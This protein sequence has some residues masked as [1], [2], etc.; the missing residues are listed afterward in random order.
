MNPKRLFI[1]KYLVTGLFYLTVFYAHA[2]CVSIDFTGPAT[3]CRESNFRI[4]NNTTNAGFEWDLCPY[5]LAAMPSAQKVMSTGLSSNLDLEIIN[6]GDQYYGFSPDYSANKLFRFDFGNDIEATP[7]V[8]DLGNVD[9]M[10]SL[11]NSIVLVKE[12]GTWLGILANAGDNKIVL[13]N[14][15]N[16]LSNTPSAT[17]LLQKGGA[18]FTKLAVANGAGANALIIAEYG[19]SRVTAV[20][21]SQGFLM[22]PDSNT[23][24]VVAG[25]TPIDI[26]VIQD[27]GNWTALLLSFDNRKLYHLDFGSSFASAPSITEY[28]LTFS[29]DAYRLSLAKEGVNYYGLVTNV[30][31]GLARLSFDD[32]LSNTPEIDPLGNF[33]FLSNSRSLFVKAY[34]GLWRGFMINF[35]DGDLYRLTF[36][37]NCGVTPAYSTNAT[38]GNIRFSFSGPQEISLKATSPDGRTSSMSQAIMVSDEI[39][40]SISIQN[41]NSCVGALVD[42]ALVTSGSINSQHWDFGDGNTSSAPDPSHIYNSVG[43]YTVIADVTFENACTNSHEITKT[44]FSAPQAAFSLP[45]ASPICTNDELLFL[46]N[47]VTDPGSTPNWRWF[48][49]GEEVSSQ[50]NLNHFFSDK[51]PHSVKLHVSIPGCEDEQTHAFGPLLEGPSVDFST[52]QKCLGETNIFTNTT[53]GDAISYVWDFDDGNTSTDTNPENLFSSAGIYSVSL[54]ATSSNGC[55]NNRTKQITIYSNPAVDFAVNPPPHVCSGSS[56]PFVN[57]TSNPIDGTI[58]SWLWQFGDSGEENESTLQDPSH[59]FVN[60]GIYNVKLTAT[61]AEGCFG[62]H[63]KA[64]EIF[65]SPS[66]SIE[67]GPACV[68]VPS[69][70]TALGNDIV[71]YY[72]EIGT[73]Y[74]EQKDP[75]HTFNAPGNYQLRLIVQGSNDCE[76]VV[77]QTISVPVPL[78]PD[79]SVTRNCVGHEA[80]FTDLTSGADPVTVHEWEFE[81]SVNASGSPASY[82]FSETGSHSVKLTVTTGSGCSYSSTKVIDVLV[83]PVAD[84][85][86][87]PEEGGSPLEV[88]FTNSSTGA[89][90][91]LWAFGNG[92]NSEEISPMFT[93]NDVGTFTT[94]LT[95]ANDVGCESSFSKSVNVLSPLPDVDV[96]SIHTIENADGTLGIVV[97]LHNKG[98]TYLKDLALDIDLSGKIMLREIVDAYIAPFSLYNVTLDYAVTQPSA[99]TFLCANALLEN[100]LAPEGNRMCTELKNEAVLFTPFPN[101]VRDELVLEWIS[102]GDQMIEFLLIDSFGKTVLNTQKNAKPGL[103]QTTCNVT[104][105][106]SGIYTLIYKSGSATSTQRILVVRD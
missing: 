73:L 78:V 54:T 79:F 91:Y 33:G 87:F 51:G 31:G 48:V 35:S 24:T 14:F 101:P 22:P 82:V 46:N 42:F 23:P 47:S 76:T 88:Q 71:Y 92:S 57:F 18:G 19:G 89:T 29:F 104:A 81:S 32:D 25:S 13:L 84:F 106:R 58:T 55:N 66:T 5:D 90:R 40:P 45:S 64:V 16:S 86:I 7:S 93:Y 8:T 103:N 43:S 27:C 28:P 72:W 61:T 10:L 15:G 34:E 62:I 59:T 68:G 11:P 97:T 99:L 3:V 102:P 85:S 17:E 77:T 4:E 9:G 80:V 39:A 50:E 65:Q 83:P 49:N 30:S 70:F 52:L 1:H 98:N 94:E 96:K 12:S 21:Y 41:V 53:E 67:R 95:A 105:L 74:Y 44:I 60:A 26:Q 100:D 63:E 6:D 2:Q 36:Q 69:N 37:G 38:P 20:S 56:T 75:V